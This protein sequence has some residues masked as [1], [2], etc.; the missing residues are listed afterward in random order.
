MLVD[1]M[2]GF[3]L[4][5][6]KE[7]RGSM[8]KKGVDYGTGAVWPGQEAKDLG[9]VDEVTTIDDYVDTHWG[10]KA[11]DFGPSPEASTMFSRSLQDAVVGAIERL[12]TTTPSIR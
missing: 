1:Q 11:Y 3:F 10:I 2:G 8:L 12:A 4:A 7:R 5:E 9:L 6:V